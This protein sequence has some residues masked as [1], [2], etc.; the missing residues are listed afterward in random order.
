MQELPLGVPFGLEQLVYLDE[1]VITRQVENS[2][3]EMFNGIQCNKKYQ[4]S[5]FLL[6]KKIFL[7]L[8]F[9]DSLI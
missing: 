4:V 1:L 5:S 2:W 9:E 6:F 7:N 3:M 8:W